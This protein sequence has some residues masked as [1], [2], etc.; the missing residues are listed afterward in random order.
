MG[1]TVLISLVV[2]S[3]SALSA[4]AQQSRGL[5]PDGGTWQSI[6][7]TGEQR[8]RANLLEPST[9]AL[10]VLPNIKRMADLAPKAAPPTIAAPKKMARTPR[11]PVAA[12]M[13]TEEPA[14]LGA[15]AKTRE[16][17]RRLEA[18]LPGTKLDQPIADPDNPSWRRAQPGRPGPE[19]NALAFPFDDSGRAGLV[20]R[21]YHQDPTWENPR[22]NIGAT[23]GLRTR[24]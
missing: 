22:G 13:P 1:R 21:G 3:A 6:R 24:F 12:A 18:L 19:G 5:I 9:P 16:L 23:F 4:T 8:E 20:A 7:Y 11:N 2:L 10:A 14:H 17:S 15:A